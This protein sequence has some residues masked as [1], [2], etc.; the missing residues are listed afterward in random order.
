[1]DVPLNELEHQALCGVCTFVERELPEA[2]T[3]F[4]ILG[5]RVVTNSISRV[6]YELN[7][8]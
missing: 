5:A 8:A 7:K 6:S 3:P 1:M 4:V 2:T